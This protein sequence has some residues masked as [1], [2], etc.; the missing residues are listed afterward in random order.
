[1]HVY[2]HLRIALM[3]TQ[4]VH[5]FF[6]LLLLL[7]I[8]FL[9]MPQ[10]GRFHKKVA[11]LMLLLLCAEMSI[12]KNRHRKKR[13]WMVCHMCMYVHLCFGAVLCMTESVV[14]CVLWPSENGYMPCVWKCTFSCILILKV[15]TKLIFKYTLRTLHSSIAKLHLFGLCYGHVSWR[16]CC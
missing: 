2:T 5:S 9:C 4:R 15:I 7:V 11:F 13:T 16:Y 12:Y 8:I 10:H 14:F 1:M 6:L 3:H